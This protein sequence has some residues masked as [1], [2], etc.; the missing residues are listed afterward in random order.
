[1]ISLD[2]V[3]KHVEEFLN[4]T[5]QARILSERDRDYKDHKQWTP[6]EE[7]KLR[8]RNQAAIV[9]NRIKPK[10]DGLKGLLVSRKTD[11]KAY[12]RTQAHEGAA[13]AITDALRFISDNNDFDS[14]KLDVADNVFVE[15]YGAVIIEV[16]K[17]KD[18]REI[19]ISHIPWDRYYFDPH[20]RRLD[21]A[22]VKYNGIVVWMDAEDIAEQFGIEAT[23][24][25][26]M[27][28]DGGETFDDR[29]K[30]VDTKRKRV[31]VCQHFYLEKG[32]WM[33]CFFTG[34]QFLI[35]PRP[36]PYL[37]EDGD[38]INPIEAVGSYIDRDNNRF[39][40]VR[41][42]IDL[43]DE[44]NHRRSKFLHILNNRQTVG[45]KGAIADISSFKREMS[46][47]DGHGEY[48]GEK[49]DIEFIPTNEMKDGQLI[50]L[51]D[52]KSELD[53]VGFNAQLSGERQG[54][55]SGKAIS[56]LQQASTN[57]LAPMYAGIEGWERRVYRQDWMRVKQFWDKEKWIRI[58]DDSQ[59]LKWVGIN[60]QVTMQ[61]LLEEQINNEAQDLGVRQDAAMVLKR[62]TDS[63]DPK[64]QQ[65]VET[66]NDVAE[67]DVDIIIETS[68]DTVNIQKE[69][70][71][72]MANLAQTGN[73]SPEIIELSTLR[74]KQKRK[75][76]EGIKSQQQAANQQAQQLAKIE[77]GKTIAETQEKVSKAEKLDAEAQQT[78]VQTHLL[79]E[80]PPKDSGV[81]I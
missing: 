1:M 40:E 64:L 11:P 67:L 51:Q 70:F 22:D 37:D 57:E 49:G 10:V 47:P 16:K 61:A 73:L 42:W 78:V 72:L 14:I 60:Q 65:I 39:G 4:I 76:I 26:I 19:V 63:Q 35:E 31:K 74:E 33:M 69:Q 2:T 59:M 77:A 81:V 24:D 53:A 68:V 17:K 20:S 79:S 55:L 15:G 3:K 36:S 9:V 29:P 75:L 34:S 66:R 21:F 46:K 28:T 41:F 32:V 58:T 54:D 25:D 5:A 71:E 6:S 62:L 56:N 30:W 38:P 8:S 13:E 44:I 43:Q 23:P 7:A 18:D 80:Q 48:I 12:P 45:R 52:A 27:A 50:L